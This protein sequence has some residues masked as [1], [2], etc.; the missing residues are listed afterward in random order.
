MITVLVVLLIFCV[1]IWLV[2]QL[3]IEAGIAK[4][5]RV[6]LIAIMAI[7]LIYWLAAILPALPHRP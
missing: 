7:Y 2:G 6:V 1:L 3:P 5:F 4:I